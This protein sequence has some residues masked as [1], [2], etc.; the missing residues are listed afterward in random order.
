[1][2]ILHDSRE[3]RRGQTVWIGVEV[4]S[5]RCGAPRGLRCPYSNTGT[6]FFLR[7]PYPARPSRPLLYAERSPSRSRRCD[8]SSSP[9]SDVRPA[10]VLAIRTV[11]PHPHGSPRLSVLL[12]FTRVPTDARRT[13]PSCSPSPGVACLSADLVARDARRTTP[14]PL[15]RPAP[16][17]PWRPRRASIQ[18]DLVLPRTT[19]DTSSLPPSLIGYRYP[20]GDLRTCWSDD[21]VMLA[22]YP[23]Y[24]HAVRCRPLPRRYTPPSRSFSPC[25]HYPCLARSMRFGGA[26]LKSPQPT[27]SLYP[28]FRGRLL[29]P[30]RY[31]LSIGHVPFILRVPSVFFAD[32]SRLQITAT[33]TTLCIHPYCLHWIPPLPSALI[34]RSV[35][36]TF[37]S[38]LSP[39]ERR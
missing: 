18:D 5:Y 3:S 21:P 9:A 38:H 30:S 15:A 11:R 12:A 1:M 13:V 14:S 6:V 26:D 31:H 4:P 10:G 8:A 36:V 20:L 33:A 37:F 7:P 19:H 2:S 27:A 23:P 35:S 25:I 29:R 24:A 17:T 28:P 22:R 39:L 34:R 32:V 16:L